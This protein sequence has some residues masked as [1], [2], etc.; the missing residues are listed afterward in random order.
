MKGLFSY[1]NPVM[2]WMLK[3]LRLAWLNILTLLLCVPIITVGAAMTASHEAVKKLKSEEGNATQN[4]FSAFGKNFAKATLIWLLFLAA[5]AFFISSNYICTQVDL[6]SMQVA[7]IVL[8]VEA[9]VMCVVLIWIFPL[10]V[11]YE[12]KVLHT[13]KNAFTMTIA[14]LPSTLL[15]LAVYLLPLFLFILVPAAFPVVAFF[16]ITAPIYCNLNLYQKI[17]DKVDAMQ[18]QKET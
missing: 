15:M 17:F 5:A 11:R 9:A 1:D 10:L 8:I 16:G 18:A 2:Q 6:L 12:N 3:L 13:I 7:Q 14:F 4:L